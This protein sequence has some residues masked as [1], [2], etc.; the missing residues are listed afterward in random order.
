MRSWMLNIASALA[1]RQYDIA[2]HYNRSATEAQQTVAELESRG[3]SAAAFHADL[4]NEQAQG[5]A[6]LL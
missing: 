4:T 6:V 2:L 3:V 5:S 1:E